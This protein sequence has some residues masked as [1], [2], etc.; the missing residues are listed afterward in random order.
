M[1]ALCCRL[2]NSDHPNP[3]EFYAAW[4]DVNSV[5]DRWRS[6]LRPL[7]TV[8]AK[9]SS[10]YSR[11][12]AG[13]WVFL[14]DAVLDTFSQDVLDEVKAAVTKVYTVSEQKLVRLP[15]H[16]HK[17]LLHL[18]L[19]Q[20]TETISAERVCELLPCSLP[21]LSRGD[22]L[23]VLLFLCGHDNVHDLVGNQEL[24]PLA[25]GTFTVFKDRTQGSTVIYWCPDDLLHLF[26]GLDSEFCDN[27]VIPAIKDCLQELALSGNVLCFCFCMRERGRERERERVCVCV[28]VCVCTKRKGEFWS[29][30][31]L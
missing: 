14:H 7:Y 5:D 31:G 30:L 29:D 10:F 15:D 21:H 11:I 19:L 12:R 16:V 13:Q 3:Q 4:P 24:L 28:C 26:P 20:S 18:E 9:Q 22:K 17:T 8:L 23:H 27:R 25:D 2:K 1:F 6:L